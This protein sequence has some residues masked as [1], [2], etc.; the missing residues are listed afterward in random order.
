V[1]REGLGGAVWAGGCV[2]GWLGAGFVK[3]EAF[4]SY[5]GFIRLKACGCARAR[6]SC[7]LRA[8]CGACE[9]F[10]WSDAGAMRPRA[11]AASPAVS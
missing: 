2:G 10:S 7:A 5:E 9:A 4:G 3:G 1:Q 11:H 8:P 6:R